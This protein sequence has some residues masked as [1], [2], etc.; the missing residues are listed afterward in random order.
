M[1]TTQNVEKVGHDTS[2]MRK[3]GRIGGGNESGFFLLCFCLEQYDSIILLQKHEQIRSQ[4]QRIKASLIELIKSVGAQPLIN[5]NQMTPDGVM[6]YIKVQAN[7]KTGKYLLIS[8]YIRASE[9]QSI[10]L[11]PVTEGRMVGMK[12]SIQVLMLCGRDLHADQ[13]K[14][15]VLTDKGKRQRG[16]KKR[17]LAHSL[18]RGRR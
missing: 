2:M 3:K 17:K 6:D 10:I 1:R 16:N 11:Y 14:K 7:Q 5:L 18:T 12:P 4:Q 15:Q 8:S 9:V 13:R